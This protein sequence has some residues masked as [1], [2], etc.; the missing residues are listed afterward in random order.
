MNA[1]LLSLALLGQSSRVAVHVE[2]PILTNRPYGIA[3]YR[4]SNPSW[5]YRDPRTLVPMPVYRPVSPWNQAAVELRAAKASR[6]R[7]PSPGT[8]M[9]LQGLIAE[10]ER[11]WA[12]L[13][14]SEPVDKPAALEDYRAAKSR[15]ESAQT[16]AAK[17][18]M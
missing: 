15:L 11:L 7:S 2:T 18:R 13:L 3:Y 5:P 4:R 12:V 8:V 14:E 16:K 6:P 10:K 9:A 17:E 1:I